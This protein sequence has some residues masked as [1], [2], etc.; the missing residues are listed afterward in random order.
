MTDADM[1]KALLD[2]FVA[3]NDRRVEKRFINNDG[4]LCGVHQDDG[5]II[6]DFDFTYVAQGWSLEKKKTIKWIRT[7]KDAV[8]EVVPVPK[9]FNSKE[10]AKRGYPDAGVFPVEICE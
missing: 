3:Y 1:M 10:D 8:G 2:G 9:F 7:W 4:V 5:E 6:Y